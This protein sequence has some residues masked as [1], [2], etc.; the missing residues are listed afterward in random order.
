MDMFC[1]TG[2]VAK[3]AQRLGYD[4]RTLDIEDESHIDYC[5]DI[6]D[7]DYK[8]AFADWLPDVIWASP[9][10]T[11]YSCANTRGERNIRLANRIVRKTL[12]IIQWVNSRNSDLLWI[13]ENPQTGTLKKQSFMKGIPYLDGDYCCYGY[14]FRKRTRFWTN[15]A[16]PEL[17]FCPGKGACKQMVGGS[18]LQSVGSGMKKYGK[19]LKPR[20]KFSVPYRLVELL[21]TEPT[22]SAQLHRTDS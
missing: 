20:E 3:V 14:P 7:F 19:V 4:V 12:E 16:V 15:S 18:H 2:S 21:I 22:G 6:L 11:Y 13:V 17:K 8:A 1:G 5:V 10:C 9:P